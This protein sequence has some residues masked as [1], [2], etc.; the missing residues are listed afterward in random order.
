VEVGTFELRSSNVE[1]WLADEWTQRPDGL[2]W[3][4]GAVVGS[5]YT[6]Y[7]AVTQAA[8]SLQGDGRITTVLQWW[9]HD[10]PH[11]SND[12]A[13]IECTYKTWSGTPPAVVSRASFQ[14]TAYHS[15]GA[16]SE[17]N[18]PG[19]CPATLAEAN[20]GIPWMT[21]G[22]DKRI[23]SACKGACGDLTC[24]AADPD[25]V[26]LHDAGGTSAPPPPPPDEISIED[27]ASMVARLR[28]G[29]VLLLL[30]R[31]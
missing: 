31:L 13:R 18:L 22:T 25:A 8:C 12:Q 2:F 21:V 27:E 20:E 19:S 15:E 23:V 24:D 17:G 4:H 3:G 30:G 7:G 16:L 9:F 6:Y 26:L 11:H 5:T 14:D 1:T 10:N 29:A 28:L